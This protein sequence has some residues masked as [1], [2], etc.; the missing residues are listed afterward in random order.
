MIASYPDAGRM[1][2]SPWPRAPSATFTR[3]WPGAF[4]AAPRWEWIDRNPADSAKPPTVT[5]KKRPATAPA[6]VVKVIGQARAT[7]QPD[8]ALYIWLAA[9]TGA[10]RGELCALQVRDIDPD[11]GVVHIAFN[12]VVRGGRRLRKDQD[13]KAA[14]R[15]TPARR[16]SGLDCAQEKHPAAYRVQ[17]RGL[18][19][20]GRV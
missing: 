4:D 2:A 15:G 7:G 8:V 13:V 17:R 9:I 18:R 20:Q 11:N 19:G 5:L 1:P 3:S 6:D 10:R 14:M 16:A 12:Y